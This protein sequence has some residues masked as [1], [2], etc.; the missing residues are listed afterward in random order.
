M[1]IICL[2]TAIPN[3]S[4]RWIIKTAL[5][6]SMVMQQF[7]SGKTSTNRRNNLLQSYVYDFVIWTIEM[8]VLVLT[9][10]HRKWRNPELLNKNLKSITAQ[11]DNDSRDGHE[12][13]NPARLKMITYCIIERGFG[14]GVW[15]RCTRFDWVGR[16][17]TLSI[18]SATDRKWETMIGNEKL[19]SETISGTVL[20]YCY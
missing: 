17:V 11:D 15:W 14:Y 6:I 9:I 16:A 4:K 20:V 12:K 2:W 18:Y 1:Y 5:P 10:R 19:C 13:R 8:I 7:V 3:I